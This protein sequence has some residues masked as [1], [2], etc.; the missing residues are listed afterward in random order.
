MS[1]KKVK[2]AQIKSSDDSNSGAPL[3]LLQSQGGDSL[4]VM[5]QPYGLTSRPPDNTYAVV[6]PI[7][8]QESNKMAIAV[9]L[10]G[11]QKDL[12]IGDTILEN[13]VTGAFVYLD[14]NGDINVVSPG[15]NVNVSAPG[16]DVNVSAGNIS[17]EGTSNITGDMNITGTVNITGALF[18]NG[19]PIT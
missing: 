1:D 16:G 12:H 7:N 18:V 11:R 2:L 4:G 19:N 10:D 15:G 14:F 17:I 8:G 6:L 9:D 5:V 13:T 3:L